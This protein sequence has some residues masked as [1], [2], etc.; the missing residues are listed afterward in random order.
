MDRKQKGSGSEKQEAGRVVEVEA[1]IRKGSCKRD[2]E[3]EGQWEGKYEV[4]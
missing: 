3:W 1:E 4:K 2:R